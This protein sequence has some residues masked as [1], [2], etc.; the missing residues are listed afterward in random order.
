MAPESLC[1][2]EGRLESSSGSWAGKRV[3][4]SWAAQA[5]PGHLPLP[6][7]PAIRPPVTAGIR[8]SWR[9]GPSSGPAGAMERLGPPL[10]PRAWLPLLLEGGRHCFSETGF[11]SPK[12]FP[13]QGTRDKEY[14]V[15]CFPEPQVPKLGAVPLT[16]SLHA[17][18]L[19][20]L[21]PQTGTSPQGSESQS[22]GE[23]GCPREFI[24]VISPSCPCS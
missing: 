11:F 14:L 20:L 4:Y 7:A 22:A 3:I 12:C 16:L 10:L 23:G 19:L 21:P 24:L 1:F 13:P 5:L 18:P 8:W 17:L 15:L 9:A 6:Q 2:H